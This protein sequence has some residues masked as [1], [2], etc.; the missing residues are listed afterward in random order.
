MCVVSAYHMGVVTPDI[1]PEA[2]QYVTKSVERRY[3]FFHF[4]A[5]AC[6]DIHIAMGPESGKWPIRVNLCAWSNTKQCIWYGGY[7]K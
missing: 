4:S 6:N 3:G 1:T 5:R 7:P 2:F